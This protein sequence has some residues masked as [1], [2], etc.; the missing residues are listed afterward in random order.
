MA[1][2][3]KNKL[4]LAADPPPPKVDDTPEEEGLPPWMATFADMVTLLL[5]FFVL[6]LSFTNQDIT[7]FKMM[8][9]SVQEAM[10]VQKEDKGAM[11]APFA[12]TRYEYQDTQ[13]ESQ[14]FKEMGTLLKQF[15]R[16]EKLTN[17]AKVSVDS[18][19]VMLRVNSVSMFAPGSSRIKAQAA[20][21][22]D[23]IISKMKTTS[24]NLMIRGHTADV[25]SGAEQIG[26][27]QLSGTRAAACL[28]YILEHSDIPPERLKAVGYADS[29]P[30]VPNTSDPNRA[31]N[32]RVEFFFQSPNNPDW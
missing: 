24:Y 26:N 17:D 13:K 6:L 10:G 11:M 18:S 19:G 1:K 14:E 27:W 9:G 8:L 15:V 4:L 31:L 22:L 3:K 21:L 28:R 7:N 32:R 5:C 16:D 23:E 20:P 12:E 25:E 30:L 2:K 29:N